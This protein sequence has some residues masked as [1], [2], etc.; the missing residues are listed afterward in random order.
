MST[1]SKVAKG[2][3]ACPKCQG[4]SIFLPTN[5]AVGYDGKLYGLRSR[6]FCNRT[7]CDQRLWFYPRTGLVTRRNKGMTLAEYEENERNSYANLRFINLMRA[8]TSLP[9]LVEVQIT[10]PGFPIKIWESSRTPYS[11]LRSMFV[12]W[13]WWFA[14]ALKSPF[15]GSAQQMDADALNELKSGE[16]SINDI[17]A[18]RGLSPVEADN[19]E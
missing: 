6:G 8:L 17:R 10:P 11:R 13:F 4:D 2:L 15:L 7:S 9:P 19:G 1:P 3:E 12:G 5:P 18:K 14:A 16:K